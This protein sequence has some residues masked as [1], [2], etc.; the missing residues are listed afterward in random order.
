MS[1]FDTLIEGASTIGGGILGGIIGGPAGAAGGGALGKQFGDWITGDDE[2]P[3]TTTAGGLG[4]GGGTSGGGGAGTSW[5]SAPGAVTPNLPS[6]PGRP[7]GGLQGP[8]YGTQGLGAGAQQALSVAMQALR[9][10]P[11]ISNFLQRAWDFPTESEETSPKSRQLWEALAKQVPKSHR[12]ALYQFLVGFPA[13]VGLSK[14]ASDVFMTLK[15]AESGYSPEE[16]CCV[17]D[18][19]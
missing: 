13:P 9:A 3:K 4:L 18:P 19:K 8:V 16:L 14:S 7:S 2:E 12:E 6:V 5:P 1:F 11:Y 15:I 10:Y 17:M